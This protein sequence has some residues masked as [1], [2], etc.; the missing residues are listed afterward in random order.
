MT[1]ETGSQHDK[2]V[3]PSNAASAPPAAKAAP[4]TK[5]PR[6]LLV[7]DGTT[8]LEPGQMTKSAFL[9]EL[10]ARVRVT[11]ERELV[12]P[13]WMTPGCPWY[14]RWFGHYATQSAEHIESAMNAWAPG[15]ASVAT[16]SEAIVIACERVRQAVAAWASQRQS[17]RARRAAHQ[18][19]TKR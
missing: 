11:V 8:P 17:P 15:T 6:R 3:G 2:A 16:A 9:A 14:V 13:G 7:E 5:K 10:Q 1:I 12:G 4:A 18:K 19:R